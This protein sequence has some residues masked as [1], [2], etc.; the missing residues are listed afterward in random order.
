VIK[1]KE[2]LIGREKYMN[3]FFGYK[4]N[5]DD[6]YGENYLDRKLSEETTQLIE[7]KQEEVNTYNK[8]VTIPFWLSLVM[9]FCLMF[10][11][12][13]L[14]A[15]L[16]NLGEKSF[17]EIMSN[18]SGL[19][20]GA[21]ISLVVG[22]GI[23]LYSIWKRKKGVS[24]DETETLETAVNDVEAKCK[25]ELNIPADADAINV[26]VG[27]EEV[28]KN[29]E[30]K[31]TNY[32]PLNAFIFIEDNAICFAFID[33]L[34]KIPTSDIVDIK[35]NKKLTFVGWNKETEPKNNKYNDHKVVVQSGMFY[36]TMTYNVIVDNGF[37]KL[38]IIIP[39]YDIKTIAD[40]LEMEIKEEE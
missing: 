37:N 31:K 40:L 39:C 6:F 28:N 32:L 22:L 21:I 24:K 10:P 35:Q 5:A 8:K 9:Y 27:V 7:D 13:V 15:V 30:V 17:A 3:N 16:K 2:I 19:I 36:T 1:L 20:I 29:G 25:A 18:S 38:A 23:Y 12:M 14:A 11:V 34:Y 33:A 4:N 26:L